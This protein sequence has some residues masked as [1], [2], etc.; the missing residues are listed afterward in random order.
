MRRGGVVALA[1][2]ACAPEAA[3]H[4]ALGDE[5]YLAGGY[6]DAVAEY[7]LA[8]ATRP[9]EATLL[10][11]L[12]A[13]A[14]HAEALDI[15]TEAFGAVAVQDG[16]RRFGLNGL[17]RVARAAAAADDRPV[18][19]AA[20]R[21]MR[22]IDPDRRL[23]EFAVGVAL[24]EARSGNTAEALELMPYAVAAAEGGMADSVLFVYAELLERVG[25]CRDAAGVY[26]GLL[27]RPGSGQLNER[28]QSGMARC[29][30]R[31]GRAALARGEPQRAEGYFRRAASPVVPRQLARAAWLGLGDVRYALGDLAG[32]VEAYEQARGG[33]SA[34]ADSIARVAAQRLN[35]IGS[36]EIPR[37]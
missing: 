23:G 2:A 33:R 27:R 14:L 4:A 1:L 20:L 10:A 9:D 31:Q 30:L 7:Q 3:D 32:A 21:T 17:W 18:L 25:R 34:D 37:Q 15:A 8:L 35:A 29:A 19:L 28:A 12:G 13:A 22:A 5:K 6:R 26:E 11:K 24:D 16:W 36:A